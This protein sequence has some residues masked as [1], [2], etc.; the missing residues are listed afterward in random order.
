MA[1]Q[2][3]LKEGW[4]R[5]LLLVDVDGVLSLFGGARAAPETLLPTLVDGVPHLLSRAAAEALRELVPD[6]D[7]VWC[8]GWKDRADSYLPHL[9]GLPRGWPYVR[10]KTAPNHGGHFKLGGIDAFAGPERPL[11][12]IDDHL[13]AACHAWAR[14]RP[15]ATLLVATDPEVGLTRTHVARVRAWVATLDS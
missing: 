10:F 4:A 6:F 3:P 14:D 5:P 11:A 13:D 9:L 15:G 12:W 7:C 8:T 1:R 2:T